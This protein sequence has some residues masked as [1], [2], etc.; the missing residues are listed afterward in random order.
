MRLVPDQGPVEQFVSA[1][2]DP[3]FDDRI[4]A[5]NLDAAEHGRDADVGEDR[6]EQRGVFGVT[7]ADEVFDLAA[8]VFEVHGE[9]ACGLGDPG[10]GRVRCGA[11]DA[12]A[13][14]GVL[15]DRQNV[16]AGTGQRDGFEEVNREDGLG[17]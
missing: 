5:G 6:V 7:V 2:L 9:I 8:G 3:S 13:A 4:H 14:G 10:G 15:D 17:L 16:H 1:G 12:D 11:E